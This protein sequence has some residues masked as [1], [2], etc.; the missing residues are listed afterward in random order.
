MLADSR[1]TAA[2]GAGSKDVSTRYRF[3]TG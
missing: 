1:L 2:D 3:E